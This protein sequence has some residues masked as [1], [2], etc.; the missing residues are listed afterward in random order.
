M[1]Q[2]HPKHVEADALKHYY[3]SNNMYAFIGLHCNCIILHGMENEK[4]ENIL[5]GTFF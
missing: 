3:N 4:L 5:T 1:G 2:C